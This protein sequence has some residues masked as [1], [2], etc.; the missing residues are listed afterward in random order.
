MHIK[1]NYKNTLWEAFAQW[2]NGN[3]NIRE[4]N[5]ATLLELQ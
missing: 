2:Q 4:K 3:N 1:K 5:G